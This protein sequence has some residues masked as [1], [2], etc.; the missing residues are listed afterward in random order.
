MKSATFETIL[1]ALND[2]HQRA[3]YGAVAAILNV[4]P[5]ALMS[6][7]DRNQRHSF[8]V[9][10]RSGMPTEYTDESM[11]PDLTANELILKTKDEL[12][13]WLSARGVHVQVQSGAQSEQPELATA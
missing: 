7:R 8:I 4:S 6:G 2:G 1:D 3:T 12:M 9:N 5:R 11:H 13:I 10:I